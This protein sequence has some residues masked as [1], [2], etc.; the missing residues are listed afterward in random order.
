MKIQACSGSKTVELGDITH[1]VVRDG[2]GEPIAVVVEF[3]KDTFYCSW[4]GDADFAEALRSLRI[5]PPTRS[6]RVVTLDAVNGNN[7][8]AI[9]DRDAPS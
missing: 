9:T 6:V 8:R 1:L 2:S 5:Q 7:S 4:V 3:G